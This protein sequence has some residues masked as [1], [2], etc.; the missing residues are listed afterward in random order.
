RGRA[1]ARRG[2]AARPRP[3]AADGRPAAA[4]RRGGLRSPG[5]R[6]RPDGAP[7]STPSTL[8]RLGTPRLP[9]GRSGCPAATAAART[10]ARRDAGTRRGVDRPRPR[11]DGR[12]YTE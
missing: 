1:A 7:P 9:A 4:D 10:P 11:L 12:S 5:A 2:G 3:V 6:R 8:T